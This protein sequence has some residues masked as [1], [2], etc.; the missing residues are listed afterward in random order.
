MLQLIITSLMSNSNT[1][2]FRAATIIVIVFSAAL[3]YAPTAAVAD[4]YG[5]PFCPNT[6]SSNGFPVEPEFYTN[7]SYM[8]WGHSTTTTQSSQSTCK[9]I[10]R[11]N[12]FYLSDN[13]SKNFVLIQEPQSC[14][15]HGCTV[16]T[17]SIYKEGSAAF[18][19][20]NLFVISDATAQKFFSQ[21]VSDTIALGQTA[22]TNSFPNSDSVERFH[23]EL[24]TGVL[25]E[26]Y[27]PITLNNDS[28]SYNPNTDPYRQFGVGSATS[29]PVGT[30]ASL[31]RG[32]LHFASST[33]VTVA[34]DGTY[35]TNKSNRDNLVPIINPVGKID[36]TYVI[37]EG[38][39]GKLITVP[40][41]AVTEFSDGT[42][43]F[44]T[45]AFPATGGTGKY[46]T[47]AN[48][49]TAVV[50]SWWGSLWCLVTGIFGK[51]C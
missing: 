27:P 41:L 46:T 24:R 9:I 47:S 12:R 45:T 2:Y 42:R 21:H 22:G 20:A 3:L 18:T 38:A 36:T 30:L 28:T 16:T 35:I 39:N 23:P 14:F 50:R 13:L 1:T 31:M 33:D 26:Y 8:D 15:K 19:G 10:E 43:R 29:T 34:D 11:V 32:A 5:G 49:P 4:M 37:T 7:Y 25:Y 6:V 48:T 44:S 51:T 17:F 40:A